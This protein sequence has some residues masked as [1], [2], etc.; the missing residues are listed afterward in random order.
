MSCIP[1]CQSEAIFD[2]SVLQSLLES[3]EPDKLL[4]VYRSYADHMTGQLT[5]LREIDPESDSEKIQ[6]L[7]HQLKS[8]NSA[9][10]ARRMAS[11]LMELDKVAGN[12]ELER[13]RSCLD[14]L[15]QC[16]N[17]TELALIKYMDELT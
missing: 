6:L 2:P 17:D 9:V 4:P 3:N 5:R 13:I 16:W 14:I 1:D 10:G 7:A 15:Y 12:E 8:S 11:C